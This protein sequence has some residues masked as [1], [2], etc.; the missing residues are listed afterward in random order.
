MNKAE[1]DK[2]LSADICLTDPKDDQLGYSSLAQDIARNI[3]RMAPSE[4]F[5]IAIYGQWGSGKSTLINFIVYYLNQMPESEQ[6]VIF[7]FNP[8]WFSGHEDLI[9]NFFSQLQITLNKKESSLSNI[10]ELIAD[11]SDALAD[12]PLPYA[13]SGRVL[14]RIIR[15]KIKEVTELKS[16]ISN[17]LINYNKKILILIDDIDRLTSEE[18]R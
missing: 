2:Y 16:K 17:S 14:A 7:R 18:T 15:P 9:R 12:V 5:V 11:F 4:G 6:P 10:A 3:I 1:N 13:S 8:W